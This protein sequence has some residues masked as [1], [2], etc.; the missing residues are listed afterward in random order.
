MSSPIR[1][2]TVSNPPHAVV[3]IRGEIDAATGPQL[4]TTI[5]ELPPTVTMVELDL[6]EVTFVDSTGLGVI[7][8]LV[9]RLQPVGGRI[10]VR[11]P[12][13]MVVRLLT[14]TDLFQYITIIDDRPA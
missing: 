3:L 11:N 6:T 14:V 12:S 8:G 5:D 4:R 9:N 1:I 13:S 7:A 10:T 2:D